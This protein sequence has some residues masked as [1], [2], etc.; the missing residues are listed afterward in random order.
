[1]SNKKKHLRIKNVIATVIT[2]LS[3][4]LLFTYLSCC[5]NPNVNGDMY[6]DDTVVITETWETT[7]MMMA[8]VMTSITSEPITTTATSS[9]T[10][11]TATTTSTTTTTTTTVV[12]TTEPEEEEVVECFVIQSETVYTETTPTVNDTC[13]YFYPFSYRVHTAD[14]IYT[15]PSCMERIDGNYIETA[16]RCAVCNPDI[17]IGNIYQPPQEEETYTYSQSLTRSWAVTEMTYYS[18]SWGCYGA[19]GRTLINDYSVACNSIPLGTIVY[20]TSS[21]GS[22]DGYYRVDDTGAMGGNVIDIFYSDYS[23]VPQ[24][25][26]TNGRVT[27][28][29]YIVE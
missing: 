22:V 4:V 7:T 8:M 2:M 26:K 16:R 12:T 1:M 9:F 15:D 25:F 28:E 23:Y 10:T 20:I 5:A 11:T 19:S 13:Y 24:P 18:G 27:C 17:E 21:D 3:I 14:C 6:E 29:V